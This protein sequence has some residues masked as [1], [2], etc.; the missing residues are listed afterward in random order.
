VK[1]LDHKAEIAPLNSCV[2]SSGAHFLVSC[3]E[4]IE[5]DSKSHRR[6]RW[7]PSSSQCRIRVSR[8]P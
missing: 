6:A 7:C 3:R 4:V 5:D 1:Q 8:W 2:V